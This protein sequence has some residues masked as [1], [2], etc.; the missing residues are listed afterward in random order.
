MQPE[1]VIEGQITRRPL[2]SLVDRF[3]GMEIGLFLFEAPPQ[4]PDEDIVPPAPGP[5]HSDLNPVVVQQPGEC[6]TRKLAVLIGA[7]EVDLVDRMA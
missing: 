6:L 3:I 1:L 5:I 2:G 7:I 4:S